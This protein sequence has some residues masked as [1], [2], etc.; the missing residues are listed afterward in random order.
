MKEHMVERDG[1]S[2][3]SQLKAEL[4][5]AMSKAVFIYLEGKSETK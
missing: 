2:S 1:E 3:I 5:L 4:L